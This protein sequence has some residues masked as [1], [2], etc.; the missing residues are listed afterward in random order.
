MDTQKK[1]EKL[2]GEQELLLQAVTRTAPGR[3]QDQTR[4][5]SRHREMFPPIRE[6]HERVMAGIQM[7]IFSSF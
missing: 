3:R 1:K 7:D 2:K 5:N 6:T 4:V